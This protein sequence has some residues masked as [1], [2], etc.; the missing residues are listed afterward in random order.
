MGENSSPDED[1]PI[2]DAGF[3][4]ELNHS[5]GEPSE[6]TA[7]SDAIPDPQSVSAE[8]NV[9]VGGSTTFICATSLSITDSGQTAVLLTISHR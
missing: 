4:C 2:N 1:E 7:S 6:E 3:D 5:I 8:I 9:M